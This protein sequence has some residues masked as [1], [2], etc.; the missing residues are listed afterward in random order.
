MAATWSQSPSDFGA[1][2]RPKLLAVGVPSSAPWPTKQTRRPRAVLPLD[3][4]T[5]VSGPWAGAD[6]FG[7]TCLI[8]VLLGWLQFRG[9]CAL[10][11][12]QFLWN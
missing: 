10:H 2:L 3:T 8:P 9:F 12:K 5:G 4:H 7:L 1:L 11:G 6:D